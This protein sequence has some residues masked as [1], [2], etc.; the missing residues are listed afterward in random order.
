V[1]AREYHRIACASS[2]AC[3][4]LPELISVDRLVLVSEHY[5][6]HSPKAFRTAGRATLSSLESVE[7]ILAAQPD[8]VIVNSYTANL[9]RIERLRRHGLMVL[10]LGPM[11]GLKTLLPNVRTLGRVLGRE[12]RAERLA[13]TIERRLRLCAAYVPESERLTAIYLSVHGRSIFGGTRGSSYHDLLRFA[14]LVDAAAQ[15]GYQGWPSYSVE[16]LLRLDPDRI[17]T[18]EGAAATLRAMSGIATLRAVRDPKGIATLPRGFDT[19]GPL[20]VDWCE[21]LADRVYG[22]P[23]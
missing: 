2:I 19:T 4:V 17:V 21:L 20:L 16:D 11:L 23:E 8:L 22:A 3:L 15:N 18:E 12:G 1:E 10:D 9:E 6:Q 14:G 13:H 5:Q 7:T